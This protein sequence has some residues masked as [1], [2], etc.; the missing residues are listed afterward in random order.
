MDSSLLAVGYGR[1]AFD[2]SWAKATVRSRQEEGLVAAE[3]V[4]TF[5]RRHVTQDRAGISPHEAQPVGKRV[6]EAGRAAVGTA[7]AV[8]FID[9]RGQR[10][11]ARSFHRL[12]CPAA[13]LPL[14]PAELHH[15]RDAFAGG[16]AHATAATS[17]GRGCAWRASATGAAAR[18]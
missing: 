16:G 6:R 13:L 15:F 3:P 9:N 10:L 12:C 5:A 8:P 1:S 18:V 2:Q 14:G 17:A 4:G 11:L 7:E